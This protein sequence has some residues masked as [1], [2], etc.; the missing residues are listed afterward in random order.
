MTNR[1]RADEERH[2]LFLVAAGTAFLD[3]LGR[4]VAAAQAAPAGQ[5]GA[6]RALTA[7][8]GRDA[9]AGQAY[10][11]LPIPSADTLNQIVGAFGALAKALGLRP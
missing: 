9:K 8:V 1:R 10:L 6:D 3:Q 4:F 5:D 2:S 11:R 7:P